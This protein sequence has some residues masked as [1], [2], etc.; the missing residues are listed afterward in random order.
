MT[1]QAAGRELDADA[2]EGSRGTIVRSAPASALASGRPTASS[3]SAGSR[4]PF[5]VGMRAGSR[6]VR[7]HERRRSLDAT[8]AQAPRR[9]RCRRSGRAR[10]DRREVS[11]VRGDDLAAGVEG[12]QH[13]QAV[14]L[15]VRGHARTPRTFGRGDSSA[16]VVGIGDRR[17]MPT[18]ASAA[19]G[20]S[21]I[22]VRV[23]QAG[24][25]G[26]GQ[27][28]A[29]LALGSRAAPPPRA[30]RGRP[31]LARGGRRT[32]S[33]RARR[34][35]PAR[36]PEAATPAAEA[37]ARST[38]RPRTPHASRSC[39]LNSLSQA[40]WSRTREV[41]A[42]EQPALDVGPGRGHVDERRRRQ[43]VVD[44]RRSA[45]PRA[46]GRGCRTARS[47]CRTRRRRVCAG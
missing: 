29:A 20:S 38:A 25:A 12:L 18:S 36:R 37:A 19:N 32:G 26:E 7:R 24:A 21:S 42:E 44:R 43:V 31:W 10:H 9:H 17:R 33:R 2:R 40:T 5:A 11:C 3:H 41:V 16:L 8:P 46:A 15:V 1:H 35:S 39:R 14:A 30:G 27:A 4:S 13:R 47:R 23:R 22:S 28:K 34:S 6:P 45:A